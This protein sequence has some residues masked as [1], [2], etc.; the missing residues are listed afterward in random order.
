[1]AINK[2]LKR[3]ARSLADT[4]SAATKTI[5]NFGK[6]ASKALSGSL[7]SATSMGNL[8]K[9]LAKKKK[10]NAISNAKAKALRSSATSLKG[11]LLETVKNKQN[12]KIG[13]AVS[14]IGATT[15]PKAT[16]GAGTGRKTVGKPN[17]VIR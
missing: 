15:K 14:G 7:K 12:N 11:G 5:S 9:E 8:S 4:G 17:R 16:Q 2:M 13:G 6:G 10:I 1:M 3:T